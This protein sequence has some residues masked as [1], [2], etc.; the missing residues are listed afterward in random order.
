MPGYREA[1]VVRVC[2]RITASWHGALADYALCQRS[3]TTLMAKSGAA[4]N[5][6]HTTGIPYQAQDFAHRCRCCCPYDTGCPPWLAPGRRDLRRVVHWWPWS[7]TGSIRGRTASRRAAS[8]RPRWAVNHWPCCPARCQRACTAAGRGG[9]SPWR[10]C[11]RG[12][13]PSPGSAR[14]T[15]EPAH[16]PCMR[17]RTR[18]RARCAGCHGRAPA[19]GVIPCRRS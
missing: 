11:S 6:H 17:W 7:T 16:P 5:D 14:W 1:V 9:P 2:H 18:G 4:H 12:A 13:T 10:P 19:G 15:P 3:A 8:R